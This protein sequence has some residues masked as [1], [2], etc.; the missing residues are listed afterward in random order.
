MFIGKVTFNNFC[1][2]L[3]IILAKTKRK[4]W[5]CV[6]CSVQ[7][8]V[9]AK[10]KGHSLMLTELEQQ[11]GNFKKTFL[12]IEIQLCHKDVLQ[13]KKKLRKLKQQTLWKQML[14]SFS[15]PFCMI[16][17]V[18]SFCFEGA[19]M[20]SAFLGKYKHFTHLT[21]FTVKSSRSFFCFRFPC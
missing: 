20:Q 4:S 8:K 19:M 9:E 13:K 2:V 10:V 16:C 14:V 1:H 17:N 18:L 7:V 5:H 21:K 6:S 15:E 11:T 12:H 3:M